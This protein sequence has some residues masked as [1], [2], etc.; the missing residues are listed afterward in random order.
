MLDEDLDLFVAPRG[1]G[2]V[3]VVDGDHRVVGVTADACD[4]GGRLTQLLVDDAHRRDARPLEFH[5][6]PQTAGTAAPSATEAGDGDGGPLRQAGPVARFGWYRDAGL[7][8]LHHAGE[9]TVGQQLLPEQVEELL[10]VAE[11]VD[12][13][14]EPLPL[15]RRGA[16]RQAPRLPRF[17]GG[18]IDGAARGVE[19]NDRHASR[20]TQPASGHGHWLVTRSTGFV[21]AQARWGHRIQVSAMPAP[22]AATI[23]TFSGCWMLTYRSCTADVGAVS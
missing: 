9:L 21:T 14:A 20:L 4:R 2:D 23:R 16:R 6:V 18:R 8:H 11:P 13:D 3:R 7:H 19:R 22:P 5:G 10:A 15:E 17:L 1:S 12:H